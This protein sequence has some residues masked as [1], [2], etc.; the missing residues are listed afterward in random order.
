MIVLFLFICLVCIPLSCQYC[1]SFFMEVYNLPSSRQFATNFTTDQLLNV[2]IIDHIRI[3]FPHALLVFETVISYDC[4]RTSSHCKTSFIAKKSLSRT[5]ILLLLFVSGNVN[6][7][8]GPL[9]NSVDLHHLPTPTE[10]ANRYG[11]G[12]LHF[13]A[14]S[15]L[16][17]MDL[18]KTW[19]MSANPDIVVISETWLKPSVPD[20]VI[21][22]G[23]YN[24]YRTDQKGR[25]GGV[26]IYV[27][28]K[29]SVSVL[30]SQSIPRQF[31][32]IALDIRVA[33]APFTIIGCYRPPSAAS[34]A[35]STLT[36]VLS[37]L[38]N[39]EIILFCDLNWDWLSDKSEN[40]KLACSSLNLVQLIDSPTRLNPSKPNS[41][42][43]LDVILTNRAHK[44]T[45]IGVFA[46]DLSDHCAIGC[47][48]NTKIP[49]LKGLN[50]Y[51][52]KAVIISGHIIGREP[53]AQERPASR[54]SEQPFAFDLLS[55][56]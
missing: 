52:F 5:L 17:K 53:L 47:V 31:E 36:E 22:V 46:N 6:V 16:P 26:A 55:P 4:P 25:A 40:F 23:G 48:R 54:K 34:E 43:L 50:F 45:A 15:L 38:N 42:T 49:K 51:H 11:I 10:F 1:C 13:N 12:F 18:L 9:S 39:S 27:S 35:L 44:Y 8:P 2:L 24:V 29:F 30:L 21:C 7:N 33:N 14:R 32:L 41:D 20:D 19:F 56:L 28:Q 3:V 37:K